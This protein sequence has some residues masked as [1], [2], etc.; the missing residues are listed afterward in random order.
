MQILV[1]RTPEQIEAA[2]RWCQAD[3]FWR[4]NI[5]SASKL[6]EKYDQL[7]LAAARQPGRTFGQQ[8]QDTA[9][10]LVAAYE[11]EEAQHAEVGDGEGAHVRA[12]DSGW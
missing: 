6:R 5:L 8:R 2:I 1:A 4:S 7:R 3:E 11:R 10:A 12:I 9:L